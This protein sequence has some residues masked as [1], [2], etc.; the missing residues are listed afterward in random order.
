MK[1][2][3]EE[4]REEEMNSLTDY[5]EPMNGQRLDLLN[6]KHSAS[7]FTAFEIV[8]RMNFVNTFG[9]SIFIRR[10]RNTAKIVLDGL[11]I[12]GNFLRSIQGNEISFIDVLIGSDAATFSNA[13]GGVIALYSNTGNVGSRNIKRKPG[14]IDYNAKGFYTARQ[15]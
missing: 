10:S 7:T 1:D 13:S 12:D 6:D 4:K 3:E 5:G 11:E 15:F 2:G 8:S 9:D 14:I